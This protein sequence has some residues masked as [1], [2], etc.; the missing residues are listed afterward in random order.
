MQKIIKDRQIIDSHWNYVLPESLSQ[1]NLQLPDGD[2]V[3]SVSD[4]QTFRDQCLTHPGKLGLILRSNE[5]PLC[6]QNDLKHFEMIA[7]D[8]PVF[9]DGRGY[10]SAREVR[11]K[12]EYKGEIRATGDVLR[13]QL[14]LMERCGFNAFEV[15]KDRDLEEAMSGFSDFTFNYQADLSNPLPGFR[16]D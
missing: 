15:R 13:D 16:R 1:E 10:S 5:E 14:H 7:I 9:G 12:Y 4:W 3:I 2:I 11:T 8:F 6:I